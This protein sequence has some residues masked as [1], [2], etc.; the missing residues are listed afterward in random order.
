[1]EKLI[2]VFLF[3]R[4]PRDCVCIAL[5]S[6]PRAE[7]TLNRPPFLSALTFCFNMNP[8][9]VNPYAAAGWYN[10]ENPYSINQPPWCTPAF[11]QADITGALPTLNP[12]GAGGSLVFRYHS[13]YRDILNSTL[14]APNGSDYLEIVTN[15][16]TTYFR[17]KNA[18][19]LASIDWGSE[20]AVSISGLIDNLPVKRWIPHTPDG[21]VKYLH[22]TRYI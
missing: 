3:N 5:T 17:K 15:N 22:T 9:N 11:R 21:S 6:S 20:P 8:F 2:H 19:V 13:Q 4:R 14:L 1:M 16:H 7:F 12:T 18:T 10:P